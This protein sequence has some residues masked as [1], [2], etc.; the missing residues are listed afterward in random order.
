M[1][2]AVNSPTEEGF[3]PNPVSE[4]EVAKILAQI[5]KENRGGSLTIADTARII[6]G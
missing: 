1:T 6:Q 5:E 3:M 2:F 4:Y